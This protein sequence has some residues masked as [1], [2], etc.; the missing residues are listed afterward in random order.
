MKRI[1]ILALLILIGC[2]GN[3]P[4]VVQTIADDVKCDSVVNPVALLKQNNLELQNELQKKS[5]SLNDIERIKYLSSGL[6]DFPKIAERSLPKKTLDTISEELKTEFAEEFQRMVENSSINKFITLFTPPDSMIYDEP[7]YEKDSAKVDISIHS[8]SNGKDMLMV[9]KMD[10]ACNSWRVWDLVI[11]SLSTTRNYKDQFNTI[12]ETKSFEE[13]IKVIKNKADESYIEYL[14][15][16]IELRPDYVDAYYNLGSAYYGIDNNKLIEYYKKGAELEPDSVDGYY[17]LG[18]AYSFFLQE[19]DIAIDYLK[20][21]AELK[22]DSID[23]Y[24]T[25]G[26]I[27]YA[28]GDYDNAIEYWKKR[29]EARP[30]YAIVYYRLGIV[31]NDKHEYVKAIENFEKAIKLKLDGY[32]LDIT[33]E[34]MGNIYFKKQ[35]FDKAIKYY[36]KSIE[37]KPDYKT[38][39]SIGDAYRFAAKPNFD[40]AIENFKKS[41]ELKPNYAEAYYS[42]GRIYTY[43]EHYDKHDIN[44]AIEYYKKAIELKPDFEMAHYDLKEAELWKR[45][46]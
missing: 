40:K 32:L 26:D 6:F 34:Y 8:W 3:K 12:L 42:I 23:T 44:K 20:K 45:Q 2:A 43:Y 4:V 33:Y 18:F 1:I 14:K 41:I 5:H 37:L 27:Y 46:K 15:K 24:F 13:L 9:Y 10:K 11:D 22:P 30:D 38:Y 29:I 7:K 31:Y 17:V 16:V 21:A 28:K 36:K 25:L 39:Y 19:Y 35:D